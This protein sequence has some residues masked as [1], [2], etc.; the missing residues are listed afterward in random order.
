[1]VPARTSSLMVPAPKLSGSE[2]ENSES[3][4]RVTRN[5]EQHQVLHGA[6]RSLGPAGKAQQASLR[7][8]ITADVGATCTTGVC[9]ERVRSS[10]AQVGPLQFG[11]AGHW[12]MPRL[13]SAR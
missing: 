3:D 9:A 7:R 1:M 11:R 6:K 4:S 12:M 13:C 8:S 10:N 2:V 5:S